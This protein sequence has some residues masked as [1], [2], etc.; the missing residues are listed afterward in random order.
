MQVILTVDYSPWSDYSG[1]AQRSTHNIAIHMAKRGHDVSVI[2]T[3]APFE[4]IQTPS[5]LPYRLVWATLPAL[6]SKRNATFRSLSTY[7]VC[8][9]IRQ[10]YDHSQP[11]V[12]HSNAEE[13]S[14]VHLLKNS[15]KFGFISTPRHP[16]YPEAL[17]HFDELSLIQKA[18][19]KM[20]EAKYFAQG[21]A[22]IHADFCS[23][24]SQ[25]AADELHQLFDIPYSRLR[26][27]HN[28]VPVEFLNYQRS[29]EAPDGPIVFFGRFS[30]TKGV[31]VLVEALA[32]LHNEG[33]DMPK[34][35]IVGRGDLKDRL[36]KQINDA[37]LHNF[38]TFKPWMDHNELGHLLSN[39]RMAVLPSRVE[40][41]SL[42][43]LS[44]M[45]VG[46]P[47]ISTTVGGTP[48]I[49]DH[50]INGLLVPQ[51]DAVALAGQIGYLI[52][53]PE[54]REQMGIKAAHKIRNQ[55]TWDHTAKQFEDLYQEA[56]D[57][58]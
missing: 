43:I 48:E 12:V 17:Y 40:N 39:A 11:T 44:A 28:G 25:W 8:R 30:K 20:R 7:S 53:H 6:R 1:G 9:T 50:K 15:L 19:V 45:C 27:V 46:T 33:M 51:S 31:D 4:T 49:I 29:K 3:K 38:I 23:P 54:E 58:N 34:T 2:Y 10:I 36:V 14:R 22:A 5:D 56:L 47:T 18:W 16:H 57:Q 21:S 37:Q 52:T 35:Y 55:L 26:P 41:F 32:K 13:G 42:A 24:P